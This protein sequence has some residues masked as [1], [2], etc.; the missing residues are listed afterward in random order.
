MIRCL[1]GAVL[2]LAI[3]LPFQLYANDEAGPYV[4]DPDAIAILQRA[5]AA[6]RTVPG[7]SF[8]SEYIGSF[9]A[10]GRVSAEVLLR[11][12]GGADEVMATASYTVKT[13]VTAVETPYAVHGAPATAMYAG[14]QP[15]RRVAD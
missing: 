3:V 1:S 4:K 15:R 9:T 11:R 14:R 2:L 10:R 7:L 5:D 8:K 6:I 12:E 13:D